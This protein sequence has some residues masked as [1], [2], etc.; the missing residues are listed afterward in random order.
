[1]CAHYRTIE[2]SSILLSFF[3]THAWQVNHA[4]FLFVFDFE[5]GCGKT[6]V[7]CCHVCVPAFGV[8]CPC[9]GRDIGKDPWTIIEQMEDK[10]FLSLFS[11]MKVEKF[12]C[13]KVVARKLIFNN[14]SNPHGQMIFLGAR[15]MYT[16]YKS[17]P[18]NNYY[19]SVL[20]QYLII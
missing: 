10:A 14:T 2:S 4:K 20:D 16:Y 8:L 19:E 13:V 15:N 9:H 3:N 12:D 1:M 6:I 17:W 7:L 11:G 5:D 18:N